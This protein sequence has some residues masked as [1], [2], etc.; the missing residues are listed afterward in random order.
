MCP[1]KK[2]QPLP[3]YPYAN[4][5]ETKKRKEKVLSGF[6]QSPKCSTEERKRKTLQQRRR[7]DKND[8]TPTV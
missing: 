7:K 3:V 5:K 6:D 1:K 2:T 8:K 4:P